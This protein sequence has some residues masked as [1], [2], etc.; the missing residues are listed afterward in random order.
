MQHVAST[1]IWGRVMIREIRSFFDRWPAEEGPC[2]VLHALSGGRDSAALLY[3]LREL[4][5]EKGYD[6]R[7]IHVH[8]G[9][10]NEAG[11]D[12]DFCRELCRKLEIP[13]VIV[14]VDALT[15]ARERG[16]SLEAAARELRYQALEKEAETLLS[17][18][19]SSRLW[20]TLA[21][22][23][24]DQAETLLLHLLRGSGLKGLGGMMP[25]RPMNT[26]RGFFARPMLDVS[27]E[28]VETYLASRSVD[29]P[30][31]EGLSH[32]EDAS[33]LDEHYTRNRI[34]HELIPLLQREYN[35]R[36]VETL[37]RSAALLSEEEQFIEASVEEMAKDYGWKD[38]GAVFDLRMFDTLPDVVKSRRL[39]RFLESQGRLTDVEEKHIRALIDLAEGRS[40][41]QVMLPH[42][43]TATKSYDILFLTFFA[44]KTDEDT[45]N[46]AL[47]DEDLYE[48]EILSIEEVKAKYPT[49]VP[50]RP[51]E[52]WMDL[53]K[54]VSMPIWR[55]R[56][57]GDYLL[58]RR[59]T[60]EGTTLGK[61]KLQDF[62]I[63]QKVP[64]EKRKTMRL[65]SDGSHIVW[66]AGWRMSDGVRLTE[67]T[68][69][70]L[71]VYPG[72]E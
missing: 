33:N 3:A 61:Q 29:I 62:F 49:G 72:K 12:E 71:H 69:T 51:F 26:Q 55:Y 57:E 63:N 16:M 36:I 9:I 23:Q 54:M 45:V 41:R 58:V 24:K 56:K 21:H 11:R 15:Y 2:I 52:K 53:D 19:A 35:P 67:T 5:K 30:S 47:N 1:C 60:V 59:K 27:E 70:V 40:G 68:K 17:D 20:V 7:A 66:V 39:R 22:H 18:E 25:I 4:Q 34:R 37:A 28:E 64:R 8:H 48:M 46:T 31:F 6:L 43:L 44:H 13:L 32:V 10:R 42:N 50:D 65:L 14:H 38:E